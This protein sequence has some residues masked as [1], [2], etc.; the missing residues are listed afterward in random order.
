MQK[1]N[2]RWFGSVRFA[3]RLSDTDFALSNTYVCCVLNSSNVVVIENFEESP[4][5]PEAVC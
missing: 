1:Q 2:N 5:V 3:C 4:A